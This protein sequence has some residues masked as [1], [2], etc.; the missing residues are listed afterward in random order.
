MQKSAIEKSKGKR[1]IKGTLIG[2]S[3]VLIILFFY[4]KPWESAHYGSFEDWGDKYYQAGTIR[5]YDP[6]MGTFG[7]VNGEKALM[8]FNLVNIGKFAGHLC[9]GSTSGFMITKLALQHL[10][11]PGEIPERGDIWLTTSAR[12]EP[13]E[14]AAFILGVSDEDHHGFVS[15]VVDKSLAKEKE[16][17]VFVFER[18]S[19]GKKVMITWNKSKTL[20]DHVGDVQKFKKKKMRTVHGLAGET[21]A[22]EWGR[23]VNS[24]V[25]KIIN[26]KIPYR[27]EVL[28]EGA[29]KPS[30][31]YKK[32][33]R[34]HDSTN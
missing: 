9:A 20:K 24:L 26:G 5:I 29:A 15:W 3:L 7:S 2:A 30:M 14:I 12:G 28:D 21:E 4:H 13:M 34:C 27:I 11:A 18:L 16:H 33:C 25:M 10:Y 1:I 8:H 17:F 6:K 19:T 32:G 31:D 22:K 23:K